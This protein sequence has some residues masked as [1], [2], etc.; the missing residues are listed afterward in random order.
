LVVGD[1]KR[2]AAEHYVDALTHYRE[3]DCTIALARAKTAD[4]PQACARGPH[5]GPYLGVWKLPVLQGASNPSPPM[6]ESRRRERRGVC[7]LMDAAQQAP[8]RGNRRYSAGGAAPI[9]RAG[10]EGVSCE[11]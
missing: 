2:V 1:S 7:A 9:D 4:S 3:V 10:D 8:S 6:R 5:P 11:R